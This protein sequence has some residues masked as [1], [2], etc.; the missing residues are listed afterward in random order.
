MAIKLVACDVDGTL[1]NK[2]NYLSDKVKEMVKKTSAQGVKFCIATGRMFRSAQLFAQE[3]ELDTP[4]ISY[5]GALIKNAQTEKIYHSTT[6]NKVVAVEILNMCKD[7]NWHVQKYIDDLLCVK[8][9]N[10][11]AQH[12]SDR[13]RVPLAVEGENFYKVQ[14]AP[15]KLMLIVDPKEQQ[16]IMAELAEKFADSVHIT[17]S[18]DRFIEV[19]EPGVN[20][21]V[22][23]EY[24][25][26]LFGLLPEEIMACGDSYNDLEML[27]F[28]GTSVVMDNAPDAVKQHADFVTASCEE[29]GVAVAL[30]KFI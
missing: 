20:K 13:I 17:N 6:L 12:Y 4:L 5:N 24:V 16:Q 18:N 1:I 21:G 10:A 26:A 23:L 8:E 2:D 29:D 19:I 9:V 11:I 25:A 14:Q 3:L 22:A 28:A 27:Q 15:N 7:N 30:E